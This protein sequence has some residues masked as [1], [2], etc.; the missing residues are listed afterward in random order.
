MKAFRAKSDD[1]TSWENVYSMQHGAAVVGVSFHP[2]GDHAFSASVDGSLCLSNFVTGTLVAKYALPAEPTCL[3]VHPDGLILAVGATDCTLK[4]WDVKKVKLAMSIE[5]HKSP[6]SALAFSENGFYLATIAADALKLWDLR[7]LKSFQ[8]IDLPTTFN[9]RCVSF[10]YSGNFLAA[11]GSDIRVFHGAK[12]APVHNFT[13]HSDVVTS[14]KWGLDAQ[15]FVSSS[16]DRTV[17]VWG[18]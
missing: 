1:L 18:K 3:E 5:G 4:V 9:P 10:D 12:F 17:K 8:T 11:C 14:L 7:K 13:S 16:M 6:V 15:S 2:M